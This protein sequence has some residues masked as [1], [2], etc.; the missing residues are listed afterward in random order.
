MMPRKPPPR[1]RPVVLRPL[2]KGSASRGAV[3]A[4]GVFFAAPLIAAD[5]PSDALVPTT[6]VDLATG[7]ASRASPEAF[8]NILLSPAVLAM[9]TRYEARVDGILTNAGAWGLQVTAVDSK[10]SP[11]TFGIA[12]RWLK[13]PDLPLGPAEVP[14][15]E[16]ESQD[17][18]NLSTANMLAFCAAGGTSDRKLV[19]GLDAARWWRHARLFGEGDGWR[20]GGSVAGLPSDMLVLT[21]GGSFALGEAGARAAEGDA[22]VS[23]GIRLQIA[24]GLAAVADARLVIPADTAPEVSV[25]GEWFIAKVLPVRVGV[26]RDGSGKD[27]AITGGLGLNGERAELDWAIF[28]GIPA[29][30]AHPSSLGRIQHLSLRVSF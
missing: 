11:V 28:Q 6:A 4:L 22:D 1:Q 14:G 3:A 20:L 19:F 26:Y 9:N 2:Q 21:V 24:D 25:G 13:D 30:G 23:G 17:R 15:W 18:K 16:V 12:Y 29:G 10:T 7:G 27:L 5:L 8:S